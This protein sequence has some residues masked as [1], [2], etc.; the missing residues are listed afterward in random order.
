MAL[1]I[2]I[3]RLVAGMIVVL[4]RD[5]LH[6]LV[7][8]PMGVEVTWG[9]TRMVVMLAGHF[10]HA[11]VA[12]SMLVEITGL[13]AGVIV[14]STSLLFCHVVFPPSQMSVALGRHP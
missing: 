13:M 5:L 6:A 4:A 2:Q 9:V 1:G 8:M 7:A 12:M 10:L 11:L 14:M 3:A